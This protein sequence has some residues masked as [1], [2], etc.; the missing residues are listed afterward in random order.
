MRQS[1]KKI[2]IYLVITNSVYADKYPLI[3]TFNSSVVG[4]EAKT[5][6]SMLSLKLGISISSRSSADKLF[7]KF[8]PFNLM[9]DASKDFVSSI[10]EVK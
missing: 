6:Q 2:K 9:L 5:V 10:S 7:E 3:Y 8:L 1:I 4:D